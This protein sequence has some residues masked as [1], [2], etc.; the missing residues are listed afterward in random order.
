MHPGRSQHAV[1][2]SACDLVWPCSA[3]IGKRSPAPRR[4]ISKLR[5]QVGSKEAPVADALESEWQQMG[6]RT[7]PELEVR[8]LEA[9]SFEL[10]WHA[11]PLSSA[12][13]SVQ[14]CLW[15]ADLLCGV[16]QLDADA[17]LVPEGSNADEQLDPLANV[18]HVIA[19]ADMPC[20]LSSC[21]AR[22]V[23]CC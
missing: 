21:S 20:I 18:G 16:V 6:G 9:L 5:T 1:T 23:P 3:W 10:N 12:P 14:V 7:G 8:R 4:I 2:E 11:A 13:A 15:R 17:R 22:I 19:S